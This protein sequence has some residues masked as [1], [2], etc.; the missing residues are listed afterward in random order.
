MVKSTSKQYKIVIRKATVKDAVA[1]RALRLEAL[2]NRPEAFGSDYEK[3]SKETI[4]DWEKQ[5]TNQV[6][7]A[8]FVAVAESTLVG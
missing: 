6:D 1:L 3:D 8:I 4:S 7:H 5:L 2:Q